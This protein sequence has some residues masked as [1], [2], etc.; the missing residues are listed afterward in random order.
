MFSTPA[1]PGRFTVPMLNSP[2]PR[3]SPAEVGLVYKKKWAY[4]LAKCFTCCTCCF[5]EVL[6]PN[7]PWV[8]KWDII[9][10]LLLWFVAWVG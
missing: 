2:V 9:M 4:Y 8:E 6:Q 1:P 10:V 3:T 5:D 7:N